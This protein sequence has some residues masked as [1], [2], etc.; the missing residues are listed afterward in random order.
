MST[1]TNEPNPFG[2]DGPPAPPGQAPLPGQFGAAGAPGQGYPALPEQSY[3]TETAPA[4]GEGQPGPGAQ[5]APAEHGQGGMAGAPGAPGPQFGTGAPGAP[6]AP[7]GFG[8]P[9]GPGGPGGFG[10]PNGAPG[11]MPGPGGIPGPGPGPMPPLYG[12]GYP[13][14]RPTATSAVA[15]VALCL[16]WVP[17][18]GLVLSIIGM[19]KT[20]KGKARG[21]GLA[22]T[23]LVLSIL[24]TAGA[25]ILGG[26]IASKPSVLDPG[27]TRG[28]TAVL[29]QSKQ[30]EADSNKGDQ[31]AVQNDLTTLISDLATAANDAKRS[32]VRSTVQAVHDDYAAIAAGSGDQTKLQSDLQQMDHLCTYGK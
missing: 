30:I 16:F 20:A 32:D 27:C 5:Y 31:N 8:G 17:L 23:A 11:P 2:Y 10:G 14:P 22:I 13:P 29:E 19:V 28:K 26:V 6:G 12:Y 15:I 18:A 4:I 21:R 3:P 7:G 25:G 1:P 9:A 24:V